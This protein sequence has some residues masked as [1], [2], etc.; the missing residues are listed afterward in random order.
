MGNYE[1][2]EMAGGSEGKVPSYDFI[3]NPYYYNL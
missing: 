2:S 1:V 3:N